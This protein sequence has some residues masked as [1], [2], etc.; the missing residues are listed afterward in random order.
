VNAPPGPAPTSATRR[1]RHDA[2]RSITAVTNRS[3]GFA[4]NSLDAMA[5]AISPPVAASSDAT[6]AGPSPSNQGTM[7]K[8]A[9]ISTIGAPVQ[10]IADGAVVEGIPLL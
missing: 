10:A 2:V 6:A 9:S 4:A 3:Y 8:S 5:R 1:A 7:S